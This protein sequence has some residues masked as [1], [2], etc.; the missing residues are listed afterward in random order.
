MI[1]DYRNEKVDP[2]LSVCIVTYNQ[3]DYIAKAVDSVLAQ[4]TDYPFEVLIGDDCS[5]DGTR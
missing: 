3:K 5:D 2:L 1:I 4:I